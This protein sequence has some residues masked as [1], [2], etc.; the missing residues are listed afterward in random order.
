M[1][2]RC[3]TCWRGPGRARRAA[4]PDPATCPG[5]CK[6]RSFRHCSWV[7][8]AGTAGI[9]EIMTPSTR[10]GPARPRRSS[11]L[12]EPTCQVPRRPMLARR[13][14]VHDHVSRT[15][16][17][18]HQPAVIGAIVSSASCVRFRPL[19]RRARDSDCA[20]SSRVAKAEPGCVGHDRTT[21][22]R[23]AN[24]KASSETF[25]APAPADRVMRWRLL[26]SRA[27]LPDRQHALIC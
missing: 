21:G 2:E 4:L 15:L 9:P 5:T 25:P 12:I 20:S 23:R 14:L 22:E 18:L 17:V 10:R 13:R 24:N 16:Q 11:R 8:R 27:L 6:H 7:I 3:G 19:K 1:A 26:L